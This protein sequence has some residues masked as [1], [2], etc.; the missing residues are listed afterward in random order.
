MTAFDHKQRTELVAIVHNLD[1]SNGGNILMYSHMHPVLVVSYCDNTRELL[2]ANL[3]SHNVPTI[4][5][6]LFSEAEEKALNGTYNGILVDLP[7]IIKAKGDEKSIAYTLTN[8]YPTL[9]VRSV[10]TSLVPMTMPGEAR[11]DSS[12]KDFLTKTCTEFP[13]RKL[14]SNRR[15]E[16]CLSTVRYHAGIEERGLTLN[17]SWGGVF[18]V[19]TK[20]ER[21][22]IGDELNVYFHELGFEVPVTV[23][24]IQGWGQ[25]RVP[26]IGVRFLHVD[27]QLENA[28]YTLLKNDKNSDRDRVRT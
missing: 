6:A 27:D 4:S 7:S 9:K 13:P 2:T 11:Q 26:G 17:I 18:I 16:T 25:R 8:F 3:Q 21:F 1:F 10:G 23:C 12:L 14:R 28:L 22:H 20:P 19:D 15:K 5:C 24:W